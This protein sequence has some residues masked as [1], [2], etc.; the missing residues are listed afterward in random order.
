MLLVNSTCGALNIESSGSQSVVL[1]PAIPLARPHPIP[2]V[3]E[4]LG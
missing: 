1:G 2:V 4:I 3:L